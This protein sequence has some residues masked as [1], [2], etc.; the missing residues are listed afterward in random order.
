MLTKEDKKG[1]LGKQKSQ[2]KPKVQ[3]G[4]LLN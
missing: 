2:E 3:R 4:S 1:K